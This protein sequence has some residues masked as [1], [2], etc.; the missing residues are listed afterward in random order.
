MSEKIDIV[1]Q[2][3]LNPYAINVANH[4]SKLDFVNRVILSCWCGDDYSSAQGDKIAVLLN[5][6]PPNPGLLNRN[7]QIKSSYEGI[8]FSTCDTVV[9]LRNDQK[10][11]ADSMNMLHSFF[12]ENCKISNFVDSP[13]KKIGI[14]SIYPDYPFH[15]RDHIFWGNREDMLRFFDIPYD[16]VAL[17]GYPEDY[18]RFTR[19]EAYIAMW[20]FMKHDEE[21]GKFVSDISRYIVD[22]SPDV[23]LAKKRSSQIFESLFLLFPK[24]DM[25]WPKKGHFSYPYDRSTEYWHDD[26]YCMPINAR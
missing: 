19:C 20:Y 11:T 14:A 3:A 7:R 4:Y 6:E 2:G 25:E 15:P 24:I 5:E 16:D 17:S 26:R 8:K 13:K 22:E 23:E 12:T 21:C 10:I 9:K 18:R 1:L